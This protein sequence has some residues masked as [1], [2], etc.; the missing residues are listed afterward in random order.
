MKLEKELESKINRL[1]EYIVKE[2]EIPVH[3]DL[4]ELEHK[5]IRFFK[6]NDFIKPSLNK[7]Y[8][9]HPTSEVS[10]I[11][12]LGIEKYLS[13]KDSEENFE[14]EIQRLTI[15]NLQLQNKQL[16]TNLLYSIIGFIMGM[17]ANN[18]KDILTLL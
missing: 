3:K 6:E 1:A 16:K 15:E 9:Y 11:A 10:K 8:Q 13:K 18:L 5:A 17:I 7:R 14:L 4:T 12:K 2:G